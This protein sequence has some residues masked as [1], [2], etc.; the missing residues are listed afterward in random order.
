MRQPGNSFLSQ[1]PPSIYEYSV[2]SNWTSDRRHR[3]SLCAVFPP[4]RSSLYARRD[5]ANNSSRT[6]TRA[7]FD[8]NNRKHYRRPPPP[9]SE[10]HNP[11]IIFS[12]LDPR[13]AVT[14]HPAKTRSATTRKKRQGPPALPDETPRA[15]PRLVGGGGSAFPA[16]ELERADATRHHH[17]PSPLP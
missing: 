17:L 12:N 3:A 6:D 2:L 8:R 16:R 5:G 10:A 1:E 13:K 4:L 9:T 11:S 7:P 15:S 14:H